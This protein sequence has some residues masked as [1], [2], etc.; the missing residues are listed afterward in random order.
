MGKQ[1]DKSDLPGYKFDFDHP[2]GGLR[3]DDPN[4]EE[5]NGSVASVE[6]NSTS[7][8]ANGSE[9]M[10]LLPSRKTTPP[11]PAEGGGAENRPRA[12][13]VVAHPDD[14]TLW[15]GGYILAHPEFLW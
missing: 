5:P 13:V 9:S 1:T 3:L 10:L 2:L 12:A 14:E 15:C 7:R 6:N 4:C 11:R 8:H